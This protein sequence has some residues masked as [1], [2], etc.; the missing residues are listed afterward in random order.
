VLIFVLPIEDLANRL[1]WA[2]ILQFSLTFYLLAYLVISLQH[3]YGA[4]WR[5]AD[6]KAIGILFVHMTLV[7]GA[8]EALSHLTMSGSDALPFLTD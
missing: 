7:A 5:A 8:S 2:L 6:A 4:S 3:V 1:W